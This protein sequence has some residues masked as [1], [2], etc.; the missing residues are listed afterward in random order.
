MGVY[1]RLYEAIGEHSGMDRD[2]IVSAG[3]HGADAGWAGF[4]YT[5][6]CVAFYDAYRADVWELAAEMADEMGYGNVAAL[7]ATFGCAS[8]A[9]SP[10][11]FANALAWFVLEE[12][13]RWAADNVDEDDADEAAATA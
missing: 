10:D 9:D 12:V 6:D 7:V 5:S 1:E 8:M 13:G 4:T 3:E 11:G 2:D